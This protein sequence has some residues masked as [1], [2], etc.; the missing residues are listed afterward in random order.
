MTHREQVRLCSTLLKGGY[1][2]DNS[3]DIV[4]KLCKNSGSL[5]L[6]KEGEEE[7]RAA[8]KQVRVRSLAD[9]IEEWVCQHSG[10]FLLREVIM[11]HH[12]STRAE[13]QNAS[14]I[15]KR[16][17]ERGVIERYGDKRGQFRLVNKDLNK[18]DIL[19]APTDTVDVRWP[20]QIERFVNTYPK[21]IV[22]C[23]G[24]SNAG[25]T[26]FLINFTAMNM[27]K[28]R[29][30]YQSS[31]MDGTEL[32]L[33]LSKFTDMSIRDFTERVEWC[34]QCGE[35]WDFIEPDA[36][37]VID[38]LEIHED[39]YKMGGWIKRIFDKLRKG[40]A[41]LAIQKP[42]GREVGVGGWATLD[43]ARLY[44]S[45]DKHRIT[46]VKA[47]NRADRFVNPNGMVLDYALMDGIH[48]L[49][50]KDW[51]QPHAEEAF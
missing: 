19:N 41:L 38:Y 17:A 20:F 50:E 23:A 21:S 35:W 28:H 15:L 7:L 43:K 5:P 32:R 46:M 25:K 24:V 1:S 9:E 27:A 6:D 11:G 33:R 51:H 16:L 44:L 13:Q 14:M 40:I 29:I 22:V 18:I 30:R 8:L 48:Y 10:N 47:K 39:H 2:V 26:A 42:P 36:I 34:E 49:T 3:V 37:N 31:E 45:I 4:R 12:L